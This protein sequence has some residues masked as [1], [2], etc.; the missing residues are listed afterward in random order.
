MPWASRARL[1]L[2]AEA[3]GR[4]SGRPGLS[5]GECAGGAQGRDCVRTLLLQSYEPRMPSASRARLVLRAAA[6]GRSCSGVDRVQRDVV[7][8]A[9]GYV[10]TIDNKVP[11]CRG[12]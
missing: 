6:A 8:V 7:Q 4:S 2:Q 12:T 11:L 10:G 1:V 9:G 5:R 3:A